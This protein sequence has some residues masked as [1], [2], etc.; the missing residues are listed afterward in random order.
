MGSRERRPD[1]SVPVLG[2]LIEVES[3][4]YRLEAIR[5]LGKLGELAK[6]ALP[7]LERVAFDTYNNDP[8]TI[9]AAITA[10]GLIRQKLP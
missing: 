6:D 10:I 8:R 1:A 7:T 4:P 3:G 2:S 5:S 9:K